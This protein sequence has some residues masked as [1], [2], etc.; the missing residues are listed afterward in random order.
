ML[1]DATRQS[2][3]QHEEI[4]NELNSFFDNLFEEPQRN[5]MDAINDIAK[6]IPCML[7]KEHNERLMRAIIMQ[8]V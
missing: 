6:N 8:E 3:H 5:K 1:K 2:L 4:S 7:T